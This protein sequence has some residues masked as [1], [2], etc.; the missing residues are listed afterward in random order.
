MYSLP[1]RYKLVFKPVL[2]DEL[3]HKFIHRRDRS[4]F[5][6]IMIRSS[7]AG[8]L[9]K[10]TQQRAP[11]QASARQE[12]PT[13]LWSPCIIRG[14]A[15]LPGAGAGGGA[16]HHA[17]FCISET[18]HFGD[19]VHGTRCSPPWSGRCRPGRAAG[20]TPTSKNEFFLMVFPFIWV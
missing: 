17:S 1:I 4:K 12:L 10:T 2:C 11:P 14:A 8:Q 9:W 13:L 19:M 15:L 3:F 6:S 18:K 5:A 16:G 20:M 7:T